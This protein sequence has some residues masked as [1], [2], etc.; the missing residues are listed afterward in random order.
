[1]GPLRPT[2]VLFGAP[3]RT[4]VAPSGGAWLLGGVG[5]TRPSVGAGLRPPCIAVC[6]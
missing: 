5:R 6:V 3:P 1:M 4:V 2:A